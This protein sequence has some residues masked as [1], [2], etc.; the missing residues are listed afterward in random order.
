MIFLQFVMIFQN[1]VDYM[2]IRKKKR[3][4]AFALGSLQKTRIKC[5]RTGPSWHYSNESQTSQIDPTLSSNS[6]EQSRGRRG[7]G[8]FPAREEAGDGGDEAGAHLG[9]RSHPWVPLS[10]SMVAQGQPA[11]CTGTGSG[12][13]SQR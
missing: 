6:R 13:A 10:C 11:T 4:N 3:K 2:Y 8:R 7:R 12:T 1:S 9:V 5:Q